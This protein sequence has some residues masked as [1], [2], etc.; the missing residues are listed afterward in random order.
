MNIMNKILDMSLTSHYTIGGLVAL[1]LAIICFFYWDKYGSD[2]GFPQNKWIYNFMR[3][4]GWKLMSDNTFVYKF[5]F[6]DDESEQFII[7]EEHVSFDGLTALSK[8][9]I[10]AKYTR[11]AE[12]L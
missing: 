6:F 4:N 12:S 3:D 8:N 11:E 1:V 5:Q 2:S 9:E 7:I 10:K